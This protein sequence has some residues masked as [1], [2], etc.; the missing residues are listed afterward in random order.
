[1]R[2]LNQ[3]WNGV[4]TMVQSIFV[5]NGINPHHEQKDIVLSITIEL[6]PS[7]VKI[8]LKE[9]KCKSAAYMNTMP[10]SIPFIASDHDKLPMAADLFEAYGS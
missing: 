6:Y 9:R 7:H 1:M 5:K 8:N 10:E 4:F 2:T 3:L